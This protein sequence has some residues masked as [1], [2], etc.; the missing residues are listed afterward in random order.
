MIRDRGEPPPEGARVWPPLCRALIPLTI[1]VL[2][3]EAHL[4]SRI[5]SPFDS[6]FTVHTALSLLREG[7]FDLDEYQDVGATPADYRIAVVDGHL[8]HRYPLGTALLVTPA[9]FLLD[10]WFHALTGLDLDH[11]VRQAGSQGVERFLASLLVAL[12]AAVVFLTARRSLPLGGALIVTF[13]FAFCTP[14][15]STAS[16]ALWNHTSSILMLALAIDL[17]DRAEARPRCARPAGLPL[18]LAYVMR[19]SNA[20]AVIALTLFTLLRHRRQF[21]GFVLWA[22]PAAVLHAAVLFGVYGSLQTPYQE[23]A[24]RGLPFI[25][26]P[27]IRRALLGTLLSPSRGLFIF[28][29]VLLFSLGGVLVAARS[30][31]IHALALALGATLVLQ[32]IL[33]GIWPAWPGG[34]TFGP[35]LWTDMM[36]LFAHLLIPALRGI[37]GLPPVPRAALGAV[38]A[39]ATLFSLFVH[40]RGAND[41]AVWLWNDHPVPISRDERRLW[42][43]GDVQFLRRMTAEEME[44]LQ[45]APGR[46]P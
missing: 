36:P 23:I 46:A 18:G 45:E 10:H 38:F 14:V 37:A 17:L 9:V 31:P 29:P 43:W 25:T 21:V 3:F 44:R 40:A 28:S 33:L 5:V 27:G 30:R 12:T 15:W 1:F 22:L 4:L 13:V 39:L 26:L 16:R 20:V 41:R 32:W 19:P 7:D 6:V 2:V 8:L 24:A 11:L 35:R 34:H 42:D